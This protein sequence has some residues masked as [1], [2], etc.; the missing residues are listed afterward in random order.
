MLFFFKV[1]WPK[2]SR[3]TLL[4]LALAPGG[5]PR[6]L[7]GRLALRLVVRKAAHATARPGESAL[8]GHLAPQVLD[9]FE[10]LGGRASVV[11]SPASLDLA[12]GGGV[13]RRGLSRKAVQGSAIC[14]GAEEAC[15]DDRHCGG[16]REEREGGEYQVF[17][18][19]FVG[20]FF[21]FFFPLLFWGRSL[22]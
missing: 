6:G 8:S 22:Y 20:L 15:F 1:C 2:E 11:A 9:L 16:E 4:A 5:S 13:L 21:F 7:A 14:Q 17:R 3:L 10:Y 18:K 12:R 19:H